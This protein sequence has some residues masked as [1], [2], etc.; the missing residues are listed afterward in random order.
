MPTNPSVIA[1]SSL[2]GS[3]G[4]QINGEAGGDRSGRSVSSAGDVN[5]DG[6]DDLIIGASDADPN[7]SLS[8]S[9]YVVFGKASGF[10]ATIELS[11]LDGSTGFQI[12]GEATVDFSG[13]SVSSAGDVNG[14]GF[15]DLIIGA[16]EADPNGS[17]SGA[18]YVV[19][20]KASGFDATMELSALDGTTGFQING[21]AGG[22]Y[23]GRSV[24]SAGDV[25]G[26]GLADLIIGAD[27][28]DP[29]GSYSGS[30]YVVFGKASGYSANLEL[31]MLDGTTGFQINGETDYD[32]SGRPVS[33]A[34]DVNGDGFDDLIIGA[35]RADPNGLSSGASY[36]VFGKALGF[37]AT[38][39]LS[40]LDGTTGFQING[41]ATFDYSGFSVSSA[42][43]V[44]GD[45]FNDLIIGARGAEP[46]GSYSG[47]SYVVFGKASG[48]AAT[49]QLSTLDGTTGF[50]INGEAAFDRSGTSV[51]CA[52]D[53]NGDGFD[54]IIIGAFA[55]DPNG[56]NSGASYVV[57]GKASGFD[58]TMELSALD[59]TTG[60]QISGELIDDRSGF[61]VSSAGDV[62][63]DGF[64]D[65]II[66][67]RYA[68]PNGF[69]SGASYVVFGRATSSVDRT[70]TNAANALFGGDYNDYL[71]GLAGK[72]TLTAGEGND[73]LNGGAGNDTLQGGAGI[74]FLRG[75]IGA[76]TLAGGADSDWFKFDAGDSGL[77]AKTM[78]KITDLEVGAL[79]IGDKIDFTD[80]L[81]IGGSSTAATAS[82]A[83]IDATTGIATFYGNSGNALSDALH[84][85]A[86]SFT[87]AGDTAG[88]FALLQVDGSG[89]FHVFISDGVAGVTA[90]DVLVQLTNITSIGSINL[91]G[92]DLTILS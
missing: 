74:D 41:E 86:T 1:L 91:T 88:D 39:E 24:S 57:F 73:V 30:S 63:G 78:D 38:M 50:Q 89:A 25:N 65:I 14:D 32:Y 37:D 34:G 15:D 12:S 75:G 2:D 47:A 72:D 84:D 83:A 40:T 56:S 43:D 71:R 19:F 85:I 76:D 48:F 44:N 10:D 70:G 23:S 20:G 79:G 33:S 49:M 51:S 52:G 59:G 29:N 21:E 68:D 26:D 62:N 31:S 61:S 80:A 46:N 82:R 18:S 4:F 54:D 42:G 77:I 8:G 69:D 16:F 36:V 92:G 67:A 58:A 60:F 90:N 11:T 3:T 22:D 35:S 17:M 13:N 66:G 9:S 81:T 45:G 53:V 55:A 5:G 87:A 28:A 6:F 7:G 27:G 64:D